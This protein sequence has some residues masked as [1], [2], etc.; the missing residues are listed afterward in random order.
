MHTQPWSDDTG[1][2]RVT[3]L[4]ALEAFQVASRPGPMLLGLDGVGGRLSPWPLLWPW[5]RPW[6]LLRLWPLRMQVFEIAGPRLQPRFVEVKVAVKVAV[7]V[8]A[9]AMKAPRYLPLKV[10]G[11]A[12]QEYNCHLPRLL[13]CLSL[14]AFLRMLQQVFCEGAPWLWPWPLLLLEKQLLPGFLMM[15]RP[16]ALELCVVVRHAAQNP[17]LVRLQMAGSLGG[18]G[19]A[20]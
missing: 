5:Q 16:L 19:Q 1:N 6:L 8:V 7:K 4:Q 15:L 2:T 11:M 18:G 3:P 17:S 13:V 14:N 20:A 12:N 9:R 10:E